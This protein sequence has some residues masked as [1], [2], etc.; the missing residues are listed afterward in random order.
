[1]IDVIRV[2][3]DRGHP[4]CWDVYGTGELEAEMRQRIRSAGLEGCIH[5]HGFLAENEVPR[6]MERAGA[7]IGQGTAL[8]E[9]GYCRVPSV[10][11][12]LANK[13]EATY[14]YLYEL[15]YGVCGEQ[16]PVSPTQSTTELLE[17]LLTLSEDDYEIESERTWHYVQRYDISVVYRHLLTCFEGAQQCK[18]PCSQFAAYNLHGLYRKIVPRRRCENT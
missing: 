7:F 16:M 12:V 11:G 3:R 9:A 15:P 10:V 1:M 6:V 14:G 17:R 5:L 18:R 8:F 13:S 4:V 2:L